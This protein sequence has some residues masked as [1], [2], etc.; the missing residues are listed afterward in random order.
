MTGNEAYGVECSIVSF[1]AKRKL[2]AQVKGL[3]RET[4]LNR[5]M[6]RATAAELW[7]KAESNQS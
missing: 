5:L 6:V 1:R 4:R 7:L 2:S 3:S